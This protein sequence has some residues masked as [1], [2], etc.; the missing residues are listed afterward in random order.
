MSTGMSRQ[1]GWLVLGSGSRGSQDSMVWLC[2]RTG[3]YHCQVDNEL[4]YIHAC[5]ER[6]A[7]QYRLHYLPCVTGQYEQPGMQITVNYCSMARVT[8][9]G[10]DSSGLM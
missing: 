8:N 2:W 6:C 7:R 9:E 10:L 1:S 5:T 4:C 3:Y